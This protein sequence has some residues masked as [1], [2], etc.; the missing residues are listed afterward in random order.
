MSRYI[1]NLGTDVYGI[2]ADEARV[3]HLQLV[4]AQTV[5]ANADGLL[6]GKVLGTGATTVTTFLAAM[7]YARNITIV[8]SDAQTGGAVITGTNLKGDVIT[9][10]ITFDGTTPVAGAKAFKTVTSIVLPIKAGSE[11]VDIGWGDVLGLPFMLTVRPLLWAT[12]DGAIEGTAPTVVVD[13]DELEKNTIDLDT[14]MDGSVIDLYFV[15]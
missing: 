13:A 15:L 5:A 14:A 9:E 10:T 7:P 6:D 8:A 1:G 3:A 11:N 12:D 2:S 4:A